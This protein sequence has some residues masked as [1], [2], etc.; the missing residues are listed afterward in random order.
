[1]FHVLVTKMAT[2]PAQLSPAQLSDAGIAAYVALRSQ[3][4]L[5]RRRQVKRPAAC[6]RAER[7]RA[8]SWTYIP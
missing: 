7:R 6:H 1:C 3:A 4:T 8:E 2:S 5:G